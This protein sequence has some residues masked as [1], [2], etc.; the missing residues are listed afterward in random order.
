MKVRTIL[1]FFLTVLALLSMTAVAHADV[2][3][4]ASLTEIESQAFMNA[5]WMS[6]SCSIPDGTRSIGAQA[7]SGCTGI[8]SLTIPETVTYIG[9][10]AFANCTGLTGSVT[11]PE[12][13]E[14]ADDA[15]AGC[16]NLIIVTEKSNPADLFTWTI[17]GNEVTITGYKGDRNVTD[18]T[19]PAKIEGY[20]VTAIGANAFASSR[21]L[22]EINLPSTLITIG[23]Y[24]FS[25]CSRLKNVNVPASVISLGRNAFY[26]CSSL[27]GTMNLVDAEVSSSAFTGCRKLSV[28][29][30]TTNTDGTLTLNRYYGSATSVTVPS[31]VNHQLVTAIG[32]EAFSYRTALKT[33]SLPTSI[34]TIGESAFYYCTALTSMNLPYGITTVAAN[35]FYNCTAMTTVS[36]PTSITSIGTMAFYNCTALTGSFQFIDTSVSGSSFSN[37]TGVE[38]WS[39][40]SNDN[41]TMTLLTCVSGA[42]SI[43]VPAYVNDVPVTNMATKAFAGCKNVTSINLPSTLTAIPAEGFYKCTTLRTINIPA[44]VTEI[45][46]YAFY[47]CTALTGINIPAGVRSIGSKS[48]YN[49]TSM[50]TL[51]LNSSST[52]IRSYAFAGCSRLSSVTLPGNGA[53]VGNMSFNGTPWLNAKIDAIA[54]EV[55]RGCTTEREKALALHDWLVN[56]TDY[57]TSY[58]HYGAEGVLFHGTGVCNSYAVTYSRMLTAVGVE[59]MT[60]VGTAKSNGSS[61]SHA[62]TLVKMNGAWYHV[63][64]T[65]DDPINGRV[66]HTYFAMTDAQIARD[67]TWDTSAYPSTSGVYTAT[68][69]SAET[70][71]TVTGDNDVE[72]TITTQTR[73]KR[74]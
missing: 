58:T 10:G 24:A 2:W 61:I 5:A 21:Y 37:C 27:T 39:F 49:C 4:P 16:P 38:V 43:S 60:V 47:G 23:D 17:A 29:V 64:T 34:H 28:L 59:N 19:V 51:V 6:G 32:S 18:I 25:Y 35:A 8:T 66:C 7:F 13:C 48:F 14:V 20:P 55:T 41:D 68:S 44:N 31:R 36:L 30:Y 70:D 3:L 52:E 15:F 54:I 12:G 26:Y 56:N 71:D 33:V 62:W 74:H 57:D 73:G 63:D 72:V 9:S 50:T 53:N 45:G 40:R 69:R 46:E 1:R 22:T 67:H 65:W 11:I 42:S